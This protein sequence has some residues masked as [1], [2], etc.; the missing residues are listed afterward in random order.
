M[1]GFVAVLFTGFLLIIHSMILGMV[2]YNVYSKREKVDNPAIFLF[3]FACFG[4]LNDLTFAI[5]GCSP[6]RLTYGCFKS[7]YKIGYY[8]YVVLHAIGICYFAYIVSCFDSAADQL[9]FRIFI[10]YMIIDL[11]IFCV[12][13]K[14]ICE[15]LKEAKKEY[16][17]LPQRDSRTSPASAST[18]PKHKTRID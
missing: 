11:G 3:G 4:A 1:M 13:Y 8:L 9:P 10:F 18:Q 5:V 7:Y 6:S 14:I 16:T 17:L 2:L 15:Y 12:T